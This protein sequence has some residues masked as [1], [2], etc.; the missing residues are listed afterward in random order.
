VLDPAQPAHIASYLPQLGPTER[1]AHVGRLTILVYD[2]DIA[3]RF[4]ELRT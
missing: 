3:S 2:Y 4:K 1:R